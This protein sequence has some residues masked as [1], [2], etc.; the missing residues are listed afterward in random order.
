[1]AAIKRYSVAKTPR[2]Y[3]PAGLAAVKGSTVYSETEAWKGGT[4]DGS[5]ATDIFNLM[6]ITIAKNKKYD[7]RIK[8]FFNKTLFIFIVRY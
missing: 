1:M 5:A 7:K 4:Y 6:E 8:L 3:D 2:S